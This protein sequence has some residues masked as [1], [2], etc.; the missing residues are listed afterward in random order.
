MKN[1]KIWQENFVFR[2]CSVQGCLSRIKIVTYVWIQ[3]RA[4][5]GIVRQ[6]FIFFHTYFMA[7]A[8]NFSFFEI[9]L[10]RLSM[11]YLCLSLKHCLTGWEIG[12]Q[13]CII[14]FLSF[15]LL[16]NFFFEFSILIFFGLCFYNTSLLLFRVFLIPYR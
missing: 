5:W 8:V 10:N 2:M 7:E 1:Q 3:E 4:T 9:F 14:F 11:Y 6:Y 15:H 12:L 16:Q 13:N